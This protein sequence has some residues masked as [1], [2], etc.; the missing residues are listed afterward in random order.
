MHEPAGYDDSV[1]VAG[2]ELSG[3]GSPYGQNSGEYTTVASYDSPYIP[4][5]EPCEPWTSSLTYDP[6]VASSP[7]SSSAHAD[8]YMNGIMAP[9]S[10]PNSMMDGGTMLPQAPVACLD[11]SKLAWADMK[12]GQSQASV[13]DLCFPIRG[14]G[15]RSTDTLGFADPAYPQTTGA[16][17]PSCLPQ[18]W[19]LPLYPNTYQQTPP[20]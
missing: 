2:S 12:A 16:Q 18:P 19:A 13:I 17:T 11:N 7:A 10:V 6:S 14:R 8:D 3:R 5:S 4:T 9:T 20:L 1:S 15:D